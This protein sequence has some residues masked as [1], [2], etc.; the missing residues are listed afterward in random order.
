[1]TWVEAAA[2]EGQGVSR[3]I[4]GLHRDQHYAV[5]SYV[6][7]PTPAELVR[8]PPSYPTALTRPGSELDLARGVTAPP[9][10]TPGRD[11]SSVEIS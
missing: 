9:F 2:Y 1:M 6:P 7:R 10:G 8:V 3:V 5:W 11:A 4:G